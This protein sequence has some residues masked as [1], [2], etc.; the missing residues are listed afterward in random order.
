MPWE[1]GGGEGKGRELS[2]DEENSSNKLREKNL[3]Y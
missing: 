1:K 3:V 2:L